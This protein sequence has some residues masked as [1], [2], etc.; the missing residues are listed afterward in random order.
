MP[1]STNTLFHFTNS[2]DVLFNIL[3]E[4]FWPRYS[5]ETGWG[6]E[7]KVQFAIPMVSFCN[8]PLSQIG[9]HINYYGS[10][11]IGLSMSWIVKKKEIQPVTYTTEKI[12]PEIDTEFFTRIKPYKSWNWKNKKNKGEIN[13]K[14]SYYNEREWR[15]IP[16]KLSNEQLFIPVQKDDDLKNIN[17][18]TKKYSLNPL[19]RYVNYII[20]NSDT[21]RIK[22]MT[23]L[24]GHSNLF[25]KEYSK[26]ERSVLKSKIISCTQIRRD[27]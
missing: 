23:F 7:G 5:K 20:I 25:G 21:E 6:E 3:E 10:Y 2:I 14:Y 27:F 16:N 8:I 12:I 4:G 17:L 15:Y 11:G 9:E 1:L 13:R 19:L 18:T 26:D 22:M 24:D